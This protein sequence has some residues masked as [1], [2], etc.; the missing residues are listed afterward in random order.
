MRPDEADTSNAEAIGDRTVG[1]DS[2]ESESEE[3]EVVPFII[4]WHSQD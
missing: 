1:D 3:I 4:P 2:S